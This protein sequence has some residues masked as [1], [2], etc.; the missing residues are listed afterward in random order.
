MASRAH[1]A[2][3]LASIQA[4]ISPS[5]RSAASGAAYP[6]NI[7]GRLHFGRDHTQRRRLRAI[8]DL[9]LPATD[10][11]DLFSRFGIGATIRTVGRERVVS[12]ERQTTPMKR[13]KMDRSDLPVRVERNKRAAVLPSLADPSSLYP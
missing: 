2:A 9:D 13:A 5:C 12:A 7:G 3:A 10:P 6:S 4:S 1:A 8:G 11:P